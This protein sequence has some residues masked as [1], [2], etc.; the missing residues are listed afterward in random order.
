[1][2]I[3]MDNQTK[4][5][6]RSS[7]RILGV[8]KL[9]DANDAGGADGKH[10]TLILT[11]GDSAKALAVAGLGVIGRDRYGVFP[12]RGK[13]LNVRDVTQAQVASNVEIMS[14][15]KI[16]GLSFGKQSERDLRYGSV[17]IMADQDYDGSHIKGLLINL[18]HHWWPNLMKKPGFLQEFVTPIV[19]VSS[20]TQ[21]KSFFTQIEYEKWKKKTNDGKG[22][23]T[24]YYKGLGTS[25]SAEGKEYFTNIKEHAIQFKY[26][27]P[28]DGKVIDMAFNKARADDRK[29]WMN[30]YKEGDF[31][32][33]TKNKLSYQ[34]FVNKELVQY[35]RY[36]L[37]RS[38]P[39]VMD[40]LKP[41]QR[42]I[43]YG[44]FKRNLRND[45]KV[46]QLVGYIA[47]HASYHHGEVS[48]SGAIVNMAQ[49]FVGSNNVN[50]LIPSGQFGT[51]MMG[52]KDAA[53]A[54]YIYTRLSPVT[55]LIF[56]PLDDP[57]LDYQYEEG[58]RIEPYWY[59]PI[60]PM[61]LVN[62]AEGI[63]TGWA[64]SVPN[65]D[66]REII[67]N[68]RL[69]LRRKKMKVMKPWYRK[70]TGS[71]KRSAEKGKWDCTG[72]V[73]EKGACLEI[74]ELPLKK[75]TQ[76]YKEFCF[77]MLP[78]SDK[79]TKVS[80]QECR[81][82]HSEDKV[83]FVLKAT[84]NDIKTM[85]AAEGGLE[86]FMKL[87]SNINETNMVLFDKDGKIRK[88]KN[89]VEIMTEFAKVRLKYYDV[90]KRYMVDKLNLEKELLANRA[91]F[92]GMIIAKKL[93][94]NNRKKADIVK[95]LT[96]LK[97]RKFG[98]TK[99]PRTG[100]EYLLVMHIISLTLER[101][102]E[103][104]KLLKLKTDELNKL[105]K[106]SIQALWTEDLDRLEEA[107]NAVYDADEKAATAA[108]DG[109]K[110]GGKLKLWKGAKKSKRSGKGK[111][112]KRGEE[113][114]N[115]DEGG[116]GGG[117]AEEGEEGAAPSAAED[118]VFG[119][120]TSDVTRWTSGHIKGMGEPGGK[121][122]KI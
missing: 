89:T 101:K 100:Y 3:A 36:D 94:I 20:G 81:E 39:S 122:R 8:P 1:M 9:E 61:V 84:G 120:V 4:S 87:K 68:L 92:I 115:E 63:G 45:V 46:A 102:L 121:R 117:D 86:S 41:T 16:L 65:Y 77:G 70:F 110:K 114:D 67:A 17:M 22:F 18:F 80:I 56:S 54:R 93:H 75:W 40:G 112:G 118:N 24:K 44:S 48:L 23:K 59:A 2:T 47:E 91:R 28:A 7:K 43:L 30:N 29:K 27:S 53:S 85:K 95:D 50:L 105:K 97:F 58:Q 116:E 79:K 13:P 104:E 11:E 12:L 15:V 88:Y 108:T 57:V 51:R 21:V 119:S 66:P 5:G 14:V 38:V 107:V 35:S 72:V 19:K 111:K 33:H 76:D 64:T 103:L 32:D 26:T 31:V 55:R 99:A 109:G 90:R 60:I 52:G 82:Y 73:T 113:D 96:R 25:T 62:G 42:K 78:G 71:I 37:M 69:F 106:T 98:D 74:T 10:C 49:D 6:S 83:H 34:D